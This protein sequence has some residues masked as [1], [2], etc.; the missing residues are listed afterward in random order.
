MRFFCLL[1]TKIT[2]ERD[3]SWRVTFWPKGFW[4]LHI[5]TSTPATFRGHSPV[6]RVNHPFAWIG[7][8][9][10]RIG[11]HAR[12]EHG[13]GYF[14]LI[15]PHGGAI[16]GGRSLSSLRSHSGTIRQCL[17]WVAN[18]PVTQ[19]VSRFRGYLRQV[20]N[21]LSSGD[22]TSPVQLHQR[23]ITAN[24]TAIWGPQKK[25]AAPRAAPAREARAPR[26]RGWILGEDAGGAAS[27]FC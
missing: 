25:P 5:Q 16:S 12:R 20:H 21:R 22:L 3:T 14:D 26:P 4:L 1:T 19:E 27:A 6:N 17:P 9:E 7:P 18:R 13:G 8:I 10:Q 23:D 24:L 2:L 15:V 11:F